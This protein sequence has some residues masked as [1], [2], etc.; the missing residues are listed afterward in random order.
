M[1]KEEK[2]LVGAPEGTPLPQAQGSGPASDNGSDEPGISPVERAKRR[3]NRYDKEIKKHVTRNDQLLEALQQSNERFNSVSEELASLKTSL[4]QR[5]AEARK[6]KSEFDGIGTDDLYGAMAEYNNPNSDKHNPSLAAQIQREILGRE[7]NS[8]RDEIR[9]EMRKQ[10]EMEDARTQGTRAYV[11]AASLLGDGASNF[12]DPAT[13]T[14]LRNSQHYKVADAVF[15]Q[16]KKRYPNAEGIP[17]L[18]AYSVLIA[19]RVM[20]TR[21]K[22][23]EREEASNQEADLHTRRTTEPTSVQGEA[24]AEAKDRYFAALERKDIDG[25]LAELPIMKDMENASK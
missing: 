5:D 9:G 18:Q 23:A 6:P 13:G 1:T 3:Q 15:T 21:M 19:D 12:V 24:N 4:S 22:E 20:A 2:P 10:R 16:L 8:L 17:E 14:P 7:R 25:A 11:E